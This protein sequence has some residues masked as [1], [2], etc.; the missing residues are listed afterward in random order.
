MLTITNYKKEHSLYKLKKHFRKSGSDT[1]N[2]SKESFEAAQ[3]VEAE[4]LKVSLDL[5]SVGVSI[6]NQGLVE[7]IY[8]TLQDLKLEYT[9][10]TTGWAANI[11]CGVIQIDNQ[12]QDAE[13]PVLL[14]P[15]PIS[16]QVRG[17]RGA[18]PTL[19]ASVIVLNDN[20]KGLFTIMRLTKLT[21]FKRMVYFLSNML[22]SCYRQLQ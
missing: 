14:Q 10:N 16:R 5:R 7:V 9:Q 3:E 11:S 6:M 12:L 22:L 2:S 21:L 19:Q 17:E 18:Q 15:T 4:K 20:G 8:S 13:F 1:P